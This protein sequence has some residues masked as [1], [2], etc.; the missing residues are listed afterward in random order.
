M[1]VRIVLTDVPAWQI[2]TAVGLMLLSVWGSVWA[3]ARVYR[4]AMLSYGGRPTL[5]QIRAY[6]RAGQ[7][8]LSARRCSCLASHL[9]LTAAALGLVLLA[10]SGC[11][12]PAPSSPATAPPPQAAQATPPKPEPVHARILAV[13]DLLMHTPLVY[14]SQTGED[15]W[16]FKPLFD[17]VRPWIESADF[18][19]A[20]L[21][22]TLTGKAYPWS[23]YPS[24]NTPQ[25]FARDV[26]A[27]G[28]DALTHANNHSLDYSEYGLIQT[29]EALE[30]YGV[31]QTGTARTPEEREKILVV[32][33]GP[34][35]KMA[36][37]AYTYGTNGV[38]L[39]HPWSVNLL[40]PERVRSDVRRA[41]QVPGVDLV[42]VALHFGEEYAREPNE[43]QQRYVQL[44][45]EAGADII[46]G[47]HVHV[48]QKIELRQARDQF[49]RDLPRAVI[50]SEGNFISNQ[51]G[52][53][54]EAGLMLLVDVKKED[55]RASVEQVAFVPTWTHPYT[56]NG[57][58]RYRAVVVEKA[59]RD[60]EAKV[61]PLITAAD[62]A[63]LKEVWADTTLQAVGSP[64]VKLFRL[65]MPLRV[66]K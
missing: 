17:P 52:L 46:L 1:V 42:A 26:K 34:S 55:G 41:R 19:V 18:A 39:P 61:D 3:G 11:S 49:G 53:P 13:G 6:L 15:Q 23:G 31:P 58:K 12:A 40:D 37:L 21:E 45:L 24:F 36:L 66:H 35:I 64:A 29:M 9:R 30:R 7:A 27:V 33:V 51:A 8:R 57:V 50:F 60:Y 20:N 44:T 4:A 38:P 47:D 25:E 43:E 63:R 16:D 54:R 59:M 48:I 62:Y 65:D 22:T 28:F 10:A 5:R 56:Q 14:A 2:A 32:D